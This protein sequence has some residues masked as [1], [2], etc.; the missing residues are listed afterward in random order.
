MRRSR[1]FSLMELMI[2]IA[3]LG[4]IFAISVP[5]YRD[6]ERRAMRTA[7]GAVLLEVV[8]KQEQYAA[9]NRA[10]ATTLTDLA[11]VPPPKV[12]ELYDFALTQVDWVSGTATITGFTAT[13]TPKAGSIM[14]GDHVLSINQFGLRSPPGTW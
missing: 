3:L 4:I 1:G 14:D 8:S 5:V 9:S 2:V 13:A 10:Y 7:A 6:Y 11:V 12:S